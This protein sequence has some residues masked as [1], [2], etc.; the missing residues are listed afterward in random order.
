MI[1]IERDG[2]RIVLTGWRAWLV[3]ALV[4]AALTAVLAL[5]AFLVLGIAVTA[6]AVLLIVVPVAIGLALVAGLLRRRL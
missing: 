2:R 4:F 1:V 3:G 5:L 6:A